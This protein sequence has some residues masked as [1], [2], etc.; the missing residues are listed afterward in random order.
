MG[1]LA[2]S[3]NK[4]GKSEKSGNVRFEIIPF[5]N[6]LV[7]RRTALNVIKCCFLGLFILSRTFRKI[8]ITVSDNDPW[9]NKNNPAETR[10]LVGPQAHPP[11][12]RGRQTRIPMPTTPDPSFVFK[13]SAEGA[14]PRKKGRK[15]L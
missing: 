13:R 4:P 6:F 14:H 2:G 9:A 3:N 8:E 10:R 11:C 5:L 15:K 1:L 12:R 7:S